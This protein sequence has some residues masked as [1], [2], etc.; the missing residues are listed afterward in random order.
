MKVLPALE[1]TAVAVLGM[2][3]AMPDRVQAR[4]MEMCCSTSECENYYCNYGNCYWNAPRECDDACAE[5]CDFCD[6]NWDAYDWLEND[7]SS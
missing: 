1:L 4:A 5:H 6:E 3:I 7:C 2:A